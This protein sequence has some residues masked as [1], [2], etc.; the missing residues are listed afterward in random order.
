MSKQD[1]I[2]IRICCPSKDLEEFY[3]RISVHKHFITMM[4]AHLRVQ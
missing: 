2:K 1:V 4:N 3:S